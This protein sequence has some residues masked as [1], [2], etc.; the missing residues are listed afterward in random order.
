[1]K[2]T[3]LLLLPLLFL[4]CSKEFPEGPAFSLRSKNARIQGAWIAERFIENGTDR[5]FAY[6]GWR[7]LFQRNG[8]AEVI[9]PDGL[10]PSTQLFGNWVLTCEDEQEPAC[11]FQLT[12]SGVRNGSP[13]SEDRIYEVQRLTNRE[14]WLYYLS[15]DEQEQLEIRLISF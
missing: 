14:F 5:T 2:R 7:Y 9:E 8:I 11:T 4:A 12:L 10:G 13:Y 15:D 3:L 6:Q 1:M